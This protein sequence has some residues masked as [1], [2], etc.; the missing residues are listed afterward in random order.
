MSGVSEL[1][2][3][4]SND[5]RESGRVLWQLSFQNIYPSTIRKGTIDT[6]RSAVK[7]K[8]NKNVY[9]AKFRLAGNS[10]S[11]KSWFTTV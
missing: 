1:Y 3:S 9:T 7:S 8:K 5:E 11:H 10:I 2:A 6:N 4:C